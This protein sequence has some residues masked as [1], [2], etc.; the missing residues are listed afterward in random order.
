MCLRIIHDIR[1]AFIDEYPSLF[2]H[3]FKWYA[4]KNV[5]LAEVRYRA[6]QETADV[7]RAT[8]VRNNV[9]IKEE[10]TAS[11]KGYGEWFFDWFG[12]RSC[13]HGMDLSRG[14][15]SSLPNE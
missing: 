11:H 6:D 13:R 4:Q 3:E 1:S 7:V 15:V 14:C 5:L 9:H 12:S 10:V 2:R 8:A